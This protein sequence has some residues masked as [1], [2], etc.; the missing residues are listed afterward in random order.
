MEGTSCMTCHGTAINPLG[1]PIE[2]FDALGRFRTAQTLYDD[3]GN[4]TGSR[5]LNLASTP[6]VVYG[7]PA[8]VS[9]A[10]ELMGLI[11]AS[12]K[13]EAC[14]ARN[15]FRFTFARWENPATDGCTLEGARQSLASGGKLTDLVT[16][17][18]TSEQFRHRTF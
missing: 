12:G 17:L 6:Q 13:V 18:L 8:T 3:A 16:A 1:F 11:A 4:Q 15:F 9:S 7:D 14:M 10:G 2:S 5:E